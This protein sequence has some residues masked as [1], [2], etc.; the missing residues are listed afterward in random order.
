M[1]DL[2]DLVG[3]SFVV[4]NIVRARRKI[5]GESGGRNEPQRW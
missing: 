4:E 1:V 2:K 5:G 3:N